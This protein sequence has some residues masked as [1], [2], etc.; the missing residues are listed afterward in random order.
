M[1]IIHVAAGLTIALMLSAH[2]TAQSA[3]IGGFGGLTF[4]DVTR[5][6]TF[7]GGVAAP[8]GEHVELVGE[9]GRIA[10]L[11]P[12]LVGTL[13]DL[14]PFDLRVSAWY[15][16]GG[17]RLMGSPHRAVRPYVEA[18]G[19]VARL[20]SGL[21]GVGGTADPIIGAALNLFDRTEPLVGGGGGIVVQG[22]PVFLDVGYRYKRIISRNSLQSLLTGGDIGVNNVRVGVGVRF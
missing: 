6:S 17:V 9:F 3:Q 1:R 7:G 12:S 18:T 19:G 4:G 13:V 2:A 15:G 21:S 22:G 8:I 20:S 10:N 5:S 14:T 16:E 11:T